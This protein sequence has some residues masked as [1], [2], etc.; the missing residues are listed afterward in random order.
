MIK[1]ADKD[2][3]GYVTCPEFSE[4]LSQNLYD[5]GDNLNVDLERPGGQG[6]KRKKSTHRSM[7]GRKP[8][9]MRSTYGRKQTKRR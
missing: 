6:G 3:S 2:G 4:L 1:S 8:T 5:I 7:I 9:S